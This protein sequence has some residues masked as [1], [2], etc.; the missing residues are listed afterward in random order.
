MRRHVRAPITDRQTLLVTSSAPR[1]QLA[2]GS[3]LRSNK[4]GRIYPAA[5]PT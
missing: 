3:T 4:G 1:H 2:V 5:G